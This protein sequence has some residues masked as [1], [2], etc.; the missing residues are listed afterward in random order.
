MLL[1]CWN[2]QP[3]G[4][5]GSG[6]VQLGLWLLG[7]ALVQLASRLVGILLQFVQLGLYL[8]LLGSALVQ[9]ASRLVGI[10]LHFVQLG[11]SLVTMYLAWSWLIHAS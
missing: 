10:L 7:S 9:L 6:V 2:I 1:A 4:C 5:L 8:W 3:S 11:P